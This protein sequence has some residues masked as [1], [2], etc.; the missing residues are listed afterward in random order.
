MKTIIQPLVPQPVLVDAKAPGRWCW[1]PIE[2]ITDLCDGGN[3]TVSWWNDTDNCV[4]METY[5]PI[6]RPAKA[7]VECCYDGERWCWVVRIPEIP[8]L[9]KRKKTKM[10]FAN[11]FNKMQQG[12]HQ[13]A[14]EKGFWDETASTNNGEKLMLIVS[15]LGECLEALRHGNL[16][17]EHI[18]EFS[19]AEE[20]LADAVI[21]IMDLCEVR[22]WRLS[23]AIVAKAAYNAGRPFR[24]GKAF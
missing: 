13:M 6:E 11:E 12:V 19:G 16:P 4:L 20:E 14:K 18:P 17:S 2:P 1:G 5:C 21:R 8:K 7:V 24:H 10:S 22:N 3:A 23:D 9:K 15:E